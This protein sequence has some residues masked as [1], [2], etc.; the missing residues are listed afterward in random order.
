MHLAPPLLTYAPNTTL[1]AASVKLLLPAADLDAGWLRDPDGR[2]A[3][4]RLPVGIGPVSQGHR[5]PQQLAAPGH[6]LYA[7]GGRA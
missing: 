3:G 4:Y 6:R 5:Q 2:P 7:G 1:P